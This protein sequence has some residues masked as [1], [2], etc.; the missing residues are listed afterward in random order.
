MLEPLEHP[1]PLE[2]QEPT[3]HLRME[4]VEQPELQ[5]RPVLLGCLRMEPLER[6]EPTG[7]LRMEPLEHPV[8]LGHLRM[9]LLEPLEHPERQERPAPLGHLRM[10]HLHRHP[11]HLHPLLPQLPSSSLPRPPSAQPCASSLLQR[12]ASPLPPP[13]AQPPRGPASLHQPN[14]ALEQPGT[15]VPSALAAC[16]RP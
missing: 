12:D 11:Q 7:H 6:Q 8:L 2:R 5:E 13:C 14:R 16:R 3:G 15:L 1:V 9:E 10:E 4:P